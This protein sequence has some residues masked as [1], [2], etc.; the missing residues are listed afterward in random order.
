MA[1]DGKGID[2]VCLISDAIVMVD[3]QSNKSLI[4]CSFWL[5]GYNNDHY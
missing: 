5:T 2:S 1:W 4:H 3:G